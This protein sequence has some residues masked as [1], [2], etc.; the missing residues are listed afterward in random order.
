MSDKNKI[1]ALVKKLRGPIA[2]FE[3]F[4]TGY[5]ESAD[6]I[7]ILLAEVED[8][9]KFS[10][11]CCDSYAAENQRLSDEIEKLRAE[12]FAARDGGGS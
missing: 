9:N 2:Q 11:A 12:L 6:A 7:E 1:R 5:S 3:N 8:I 10:T 4:A